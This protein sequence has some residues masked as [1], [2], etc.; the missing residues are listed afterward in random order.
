MPFGIKSVCS[1]DSRSLMEGAKILIGRMNLLEKYISYSETTFSMANLGEPQGEE[2]LACEKLLASPTRHSWNFM[3]S[4]LLLEARLVVYSEQP[5]TITIQQ[6]A[7]SLPKAKGHS[8]TSL[9][10]RKIIGI[11]IGRM[12][13]TR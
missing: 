12:S 6:S 7:K 11:Y 2:K 3:V 9:S 13:S 1:N 4:Q 5:L 10:V 8:L